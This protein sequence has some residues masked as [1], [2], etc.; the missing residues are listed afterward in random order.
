MSPDDFIITCFCLVDET[1]P[2]LA[3][4]KWVRERG[5]KP[6][7]SDCKVIFFNL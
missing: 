1:L 7:L 2:C 5:S 4:D 6:T 3:E